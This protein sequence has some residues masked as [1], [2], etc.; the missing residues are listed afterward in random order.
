MKKQNQR[1]Y[2]LIELLVA[3]AILGVVMLSILSLFVW[4]R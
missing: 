2:N 3:I 1:G 4:G